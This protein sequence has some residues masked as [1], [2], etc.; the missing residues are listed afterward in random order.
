M[1][2]GIPI[3][4]REIPCRGAACRARSSKAFAM[5]ENNTIFCRYQ[6]YPG[7]GTRALDPRQSGMKE[8][9]GFL[10][11]T[12]LGE[13]VNRRRFRLQS[14]RS[15]EKRHP[16]VKQQRDPRSLRPSRRLSKH[17][18]NKSLADAGLVRYAKATFDAG[19]HISLF[20]PVANGSR[21]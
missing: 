1:R 7:E 6:Q 4:V 20:I 13:S 8:N 3:D 12:A 14:L 2:R 11:Q 17:A 5:S 19:E 21:R 10:S 18:E 15:R 16:C 9:A